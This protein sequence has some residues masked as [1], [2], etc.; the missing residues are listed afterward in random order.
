MNTIS[1]VEL[2]GYVELV[3]FHEIWPGHTLT[4]EKQKV[5][6]LYCVSGK[7]K[8]VGKLFQAVT[9]QDYKK[10]TNKNTGKPRG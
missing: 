5:V 2:I 4:I 7:R 3:D 8:M 10:I 1:C 9:L 6:Y